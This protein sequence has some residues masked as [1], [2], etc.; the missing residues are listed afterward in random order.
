MHVLR[1]WVKPE[2]LNQHGS[3]FGGSLLRWIDEE[4]AI[5]AIYQT[6][7]RRLVTKYFSEIE[8]LASAQQG[9]MIELQFRV[10]SFGRTSITLSC[11]VEKT[12]TG[13]E[14]VNVSKIVFVGLDANGTPTPHGYSSPTSDKS[15]LTA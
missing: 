4:A 3:L 6:G 1:K 5:F 12:V 7:N 15:R 9:D 8:F 10:V 11:H 13:E 2:D 14:L